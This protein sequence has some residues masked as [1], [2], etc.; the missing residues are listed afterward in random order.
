MHPPQVRLACLS[1]VAANLHF[2]VHSI[3]KL[4]HDVL[5]LDLLCTVR[6]RPSDPWMTIRSLSSRDASTIT[7]TGEETPQLHRASGLVQSAVSG[8]LPQPWSRTPQRLT[9][10][11]FPM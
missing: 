5:L 10:E 6:I 4:A 7:K 9:G 11:A 2:L 3:T 1:A 8:T